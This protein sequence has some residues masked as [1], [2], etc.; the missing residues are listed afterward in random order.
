V[1]TVGLVDRI[2]KILVRKTE[3]YTKNYTI[4]NTTIY[5]Y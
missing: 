1:K 4:I 5:F 3:K 2:F